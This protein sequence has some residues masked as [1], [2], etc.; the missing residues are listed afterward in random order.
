MP[1][2][3]YPRDVRMWLELMPER[4]DGRKTMLTW[5]VRC[6]TAAA[7]ELVMAR[8]DAFCASLDR[9]VVADEAKK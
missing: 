8:F 7:L 9:L 1:A 3:E 6:R 5:N 2:I 4:G